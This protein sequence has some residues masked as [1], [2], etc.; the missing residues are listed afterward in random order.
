MSDD[1]VSLRMLVVSATQAE[2]ELWRNGASLASVPIEVA[3]A[4]DAASAS[5]LLAQVAST[6]QFSITP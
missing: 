4:S 5:A 1:F 3:E 6:S 2:R